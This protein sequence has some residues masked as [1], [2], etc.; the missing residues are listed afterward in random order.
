MWI[1]LGL[2]GII[3][4]LFPKISWWLSNWWRVNPGSEPSKVSLH[5]YRISGIVWI[6]VSIVLYLT[7]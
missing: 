1:I 3:S 4:L 7:L 2:L 6:L 5:I